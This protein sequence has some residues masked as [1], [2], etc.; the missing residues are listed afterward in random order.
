MLF[1][2]FCLKEATTEKPTAV[3]TAHERRV[4]R[5]VQQNRTLKT[6]A[7]SIQ[8][9]KLV[10]LFPDCTCNNSSCLAEITVKAQVSCSAWQPKLVN[11]KLRAP[12]DCLPKVILH[13]NQAQWEREREKESCCR[14]VQPPTQPTDALYNP[15]RQGRSETIN[16]FTKRNQKQTKLATSEESKRTH[17]A[18]KKVCGNSK[19]CT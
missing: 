9:S 10:V 13:S 17:K 11:N 14:S 19:L 3:L 16:H 4:C 2:N 7:L 5:L 8:V 6:R 15:L 1:A 18:E 12:T